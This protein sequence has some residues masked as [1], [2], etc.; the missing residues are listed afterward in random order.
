MDLKEVLKIIISIV[1]GGTIGHIL[2]RNVDQDLILIS[3]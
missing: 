2:Y 3:Y 1:A